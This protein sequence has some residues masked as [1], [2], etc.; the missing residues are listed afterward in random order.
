MLV[1]IKASGTK[2]T[3]VLETVKQNSI[4][5]RNKV[6]SAQPVSVLSLIWEPYISYLGPGVA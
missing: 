2:L 6:P 1:N 5:K 3:A 4:H